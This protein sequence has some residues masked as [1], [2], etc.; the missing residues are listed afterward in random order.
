MD[1]EVT[2]EATLLPPPVDTLLLFEE[3][4]IVIN[5]GGLGEE[6]LLVVLF[7]FE[8]ETDV[9]GGGLVGG[10]SL[11]LWPDD[12]AAG[13]LLLDNDSMELTAEDAP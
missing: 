3:L 8:L 12:D 13:S 6:I 5:G 10:V 2:V 4:V 7:S 11:S 1:F 9:G